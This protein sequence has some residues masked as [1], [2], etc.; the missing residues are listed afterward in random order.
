M[1]KRIS[2]KSLR[3]VLVVLSS[4]II[5]LLALSGSRSRFS[6][7]EVKHPWLHSPVI[8]DFNFPVNKSPEEIKT[9]R[10]S[11]SRT[12]QPYYNIYDTIADSKVR[13]MHSALIS[14]GVPPQIIRHTTRELY[15]AYQKGIVGMEDIRAMREHARSAIR[16]IN[17]VSVTS[18]KIDELYSIRSAYEHIVTADTV[19][20]PRQQMSELG[21]EHF[22]TTNLRL[23]SAKTETQLEALLATL[24]TSTGVVYKGEKIIDRGEIITPMHLRKL[25]SYDQ[26][27]GKL[28]DSRGVFNIGLLGRLIMVVLLVYALVVYLGLFRRDLID[29]PNTLYLIFSLVTIFPVA[30]S[31]IVSMHTSAYVIPFAMVA[32]FIR[33]FVDTRTAYMAYMITII[34]SAMAFPDDAYKFLLVQMAAGLVAIYS[35]KE[36]TE[37]AQLLRTALYSTFLMMLLGFAYDMTQVSRIS[38]ISLTWYFYAVAQGVGLIFAY[39]LMYL[40]E[41]VFGFTSSVTLVELNNIN[42][43]ALRKMTK[44]AQGTFIHSM[45]VANLAA[46]VADAIGAKVQLVR[47][48]ALYHDIGKMESPTHFTENQSGFNP[49]DS[50]SED[51]SAEIIISHVTGGLRMAEKFHLPRVVRDFIETHHGHSMV[52]YFYIQ[53][54]N[55]YGE[56]ATDKAAFTYPGRNPFTR[57]QA[58]LMMADSVEAASRSLGTYTEEAISALVEKIVDSQVAGGYFKE[59]PITF[60][61]ITIAK[62]VFVES[63]KVIYHTRIAY[64]ELEKDNPQAKIPFAKYDVAHHHFHFSNGIRW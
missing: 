5:I 14:R 39:P 55:K 38:D 26:A 51:K 25:Q 35:L 36:L 29:E 12:F 10:D 52:R 1:T 59:C 44:V 33:I 7:Y 53:S 22:L 16:V 31:L 43:P 4:V 6:T 18:R 62:R 49:H 58:I 61:D 30:T 64:P 57:E 46:E 27:M 40:I 23:D 47:T 3:I 17:G 15:L 54:V 60:R 48:G 9:A 13:K 11:L 21:I 41:K 56:A 32:I 24:E 37:R 8:A 34:V 42:A 45:Q 20:Y 19:R 50:L 2:N 28:S 63:L